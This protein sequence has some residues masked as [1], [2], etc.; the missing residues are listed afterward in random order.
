MRP[1][2]Y[3]IIG[4]TTTLTVIGFIFGVVVGVLQYLKVIYIYIYKVL[5]YVVPKVSKLCVLRKKDFEI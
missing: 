5:L 2:S 4:A 3:I 1:S